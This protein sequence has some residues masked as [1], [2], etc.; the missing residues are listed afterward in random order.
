MWI[1]TLIQDL[2]AQHQAFKLC[3]V[4]SLLCS[5]AKSV[6]YQLEWSAYCN[7]ICVDGEIL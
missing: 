3:A 5:I 4:N 1:T 6:K 2:Q 7:T